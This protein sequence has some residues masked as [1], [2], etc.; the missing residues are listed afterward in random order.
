MST[1]YVKI[2]ATPMSSQKRRYEL[3]RRAELQERTRRR[4]T[5]AAVDLHGSVGPART[6][7]SAVAE[8]AGVQRSTVY[9]HFPDEM[10]LFTACSTHWAE[11]HPPPD[12][13]RWAAVADPGERLA[14]ALGELYAWYRENEEMLANLQRDEDEVPVLKRLMTAMHGYAQAVVDVLAAGRPQRGRAR[15][16]ER[17]AIAH[18]VAFD[19]WRSLA[20][21]LDDGEAGDLMTRLVDCA[22]R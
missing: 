14:Q 21:E 15:R 6:S 9:R 1:V 11:R 8:R 3:K 7:I 4:I 5:E 12:L 13:E 22:A 17:A 19:T 10:A 16:R 2:G 18:A 20:R